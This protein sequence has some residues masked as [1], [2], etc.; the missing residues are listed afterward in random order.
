MNKLKKVWNEHRVMVVL[1][2][3]VLV[4]MFVITGVMFKYFFGVSA[5]SYGDRL[6]DIQDVVFDEVAKD[7]LSEAYKDEH[8]KSVHIETRGK[9]IY[10]R[11]KY[12]ETVS[13]SDA[14]TKSFEA[15]Q[16]I[17][18]KYRKL[19]DF[20]VTLS[21]DALEIGT[22]YY[23]MGAKNV[24]SENFVWSNNTPIKAEE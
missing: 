12:D 14:Q 3:I 23:L 22:G 1:G 10:V 17:D 9:I 8:L 16:T 24:S 13:L 7:S 18:E 19:Y 20:N 21:Q 5:S 4:C 11:A 2:I 6:N 15:F